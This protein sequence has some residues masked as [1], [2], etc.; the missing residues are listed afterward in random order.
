MAPLFNS[1]CMTSIPVPTT[2]TFSMM[3]KLV[4][5]LCASL[6]MRLSWPNRVLMKD[7]K[8]GRP[9]K[10]LSPSDATFGFLLVFTVHHFAF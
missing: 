10:S 4:C 3:E 8:A 2:G 1:T 6:F 5:C 7:Q 9:F